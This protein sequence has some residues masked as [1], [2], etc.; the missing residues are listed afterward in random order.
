MEEQGYNSAGFKRVCISYA[1]AHIVGA[2]R[3]STEDIVNAEVLRNRFFSVILLNVKVQQ[4]IY[5]DKSLFIDS[6]ELTA[7]CGG[8]K[9]KVLAVT[10]Y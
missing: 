8:K 5:R 1:A 6:A 2:L 9:L 10:P 4:Y 7:T 3:C